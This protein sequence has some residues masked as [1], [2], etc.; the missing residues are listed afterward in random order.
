MILNKAEMDWDLMAVQ[1]ILD[2]AEMDRDL[3][4]VQTILNKDRIVFD[5]GLEDKMAYLLTSF[6]L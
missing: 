1:T 6:L 2:K 3:M 4:A 5:R